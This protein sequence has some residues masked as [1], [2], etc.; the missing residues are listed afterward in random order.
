MSAIPPLP[1]E[2]YGNATI[3]GTPAPAGT[4]ITAHIG[5]I[6]V[7]NITI[8][9]VGAYGGSG[10]FDKRLVVNGD[11]K[12]IGQFI[13]F[14]AEGTEAAQKVKLWAGE[15]QR[16]DLTFTP[17]AAG[18]IDASLTPS[19]QTNTPDIPTAEPTKKSPLVAAPVIAGFLAL[20]FFAR[21]S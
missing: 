7:G 4:L 8:T 15:S 16:L 2:F 21:R 18:T 17:G 20:V 12:Q 1:Y 5:D 19:Q 10:T 6:E 3:N 13:T 14:R 11:E 9:A